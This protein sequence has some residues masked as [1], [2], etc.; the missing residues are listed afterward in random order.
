MIQRITQSILGGELQLETPH[1]DE[2]DV[3]LG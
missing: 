1:E 2:T 3:E